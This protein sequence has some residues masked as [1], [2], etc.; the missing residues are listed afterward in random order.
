MAAG[1]A[2]LPLFGLEAPSL[3]EGTDANTIVL[4][5][6]PGSVILAW[7]LSRLSRQMAGGVVRRWFVLILLVWVCSAVIVVLEAFSF[8]DT[9]A[10]SST[11][12]GTF[13]MLNLLLPCITLSGAVALLYR[14]R[15]A[16]RGRAWRAFWARRSPADWAWRLGLV[17]LAYPA[18]YIAFGLLVQPFI[19]SYYAQGAYGLTLPTWRQLVVLQLARS[20]LL[21]L[22]CLPALIAWR[23]ARR[24]LFWTMGTTICACTAFMPVMAAYWFPWQLRLYHGMELLA[25]GLAYSAVLVGLLASRK[26]GETRTIEN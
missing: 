14:P 13:T 10:V 12:A 11:G 3:P 6:L 17:L 5:F 9:G 15:D 22:A 25:G 26:N 23:G 1:G 24:A 21:V 7:P 4:W 8:M 20:A 18:I 19:V 16:S 2:A